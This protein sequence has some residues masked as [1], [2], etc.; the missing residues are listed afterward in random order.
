MKNSFDVGDIHV[1][2]IIHET[3]F[4]SLLMV[5]PQPLFTRPLK[6]VSWNNLQGFHQSV[7]SDHLH[8]FLDEGHLTLICMAVVWPSA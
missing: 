8:G 3:I 4:F 2:L 5:S 7:S 1:P 6:E